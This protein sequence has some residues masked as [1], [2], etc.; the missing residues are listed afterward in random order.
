M[1]E[2]DDPLNQ[3]QPGYTGAAW[4][5]INLRLWGISKMTQL[6]ISGM[7]S[8]LKII[9]PFLAIMKHCH[10]TKQAAIAS[11]TPQI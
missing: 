6:P 4:H 2:R 8:A 11:P 1:G 7:Q 5:I 3:N 10:S 9:Q